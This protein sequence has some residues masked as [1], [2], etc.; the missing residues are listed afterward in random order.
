MNE[1]MNHKGVCRT[2]PATPGLSIIH[3]VYAKDYLFFRNETLQRVLASCA[4]LIFIIWANTMKFKISKK[5]NP[6]GLTKSDSQA[7]NRY[8]KLNMFHIVMKYMC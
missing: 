7:A 8:L 4:V 1:L 2:A 6:M 3:L 5:N